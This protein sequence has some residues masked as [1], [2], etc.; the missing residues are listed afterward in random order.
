MH[1]VWKVRHARGSGV[2]P[3]R[4][5][6]CLHASG[7]LEQAANG[8]SNEALAEDCKV[9]IDGHQVLTRDLPSTKQECQAACSLFRRVPKTAKSDY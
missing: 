2:I 3:E 7:R 1:N 6:V 5:Q 8:S 4:L 9:R